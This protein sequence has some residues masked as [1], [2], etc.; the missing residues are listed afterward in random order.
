MGAGRGGAGLLLFRAPGV[1]TL[2]SQAP[3]RWGLL[4]KMTTLYLSQRPL[5]MAGGRDGEINKYKDQCWR[6]LGKK[7]YLSAE[8]AAVGGMG[9]PGQWQKAC[10]P[11]QPCSKL[12]SLRLGTES[13]PLASFKELLSSGGLG[14]FSWIT[15]SLHRI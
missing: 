1:P 10:Q 8:E 5:T 12:C 13:H 11:S 4:G 9:M 3:L 14:S 2:G 15:N 7:A 6:P